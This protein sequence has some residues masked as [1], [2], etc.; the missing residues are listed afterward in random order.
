MVTR[1][2]HALVVYREGMQGVLHVMGEDRE[3]GYTCTFDGE[4]VWSKPRKQKALTRN[5]P[6]HASS[7][8]GG[9]APP[10]PSAPPAPPASPA[11]AAAA[12]AW[13]EYD[14]GMTSSHRMM[15]R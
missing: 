8:L 6:P 4:Q 12:S 1:S 15:G 10:P 3:R 11:A 14:E 9:S 5:V 13:K 7:Y 2:K